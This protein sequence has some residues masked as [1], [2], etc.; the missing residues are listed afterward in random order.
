MSSR[1]ILQLLI[2]PSSKL[3]YGRAAQERSW[4]GR[5]MYFQTASRLLKEERS[6]PVR[7]GGGGLGM[8][9]TNSGATATAQGGKKSSKGLAKTNWSRPTQKNT[10]AT[11]TVDGKRVAPKRD[12]SKPVDLHSE[13][14]AGETH[15][16][17]ERH[18]NKFSKPPLKR[19]ETQAQKRER[20]KREEELAALAKEEEKERQQIA[21]R[22]AK[23]KAKEKEEQ[24]NQMKDV[25]IP[26][27]INVANLSKVLGIR[28]EQLIRTMDEL[29]MGNTSHD[30]MLNADE[31]SLI[32]MQLDMNP[33]VD[34]R[35]S[36]DLFPR[37]VT[38][39]EI[40]QTNRH[41]WHI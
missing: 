29:E 26:E 31:S 13:K 19:A 22:K 11:T 16:M 12:W 28:I 21:M 18:V 37:Q 10:T 17:H 1:K 15:K 5:P 34:S 40:A 8:P 9:S 39:T 23:Q 6:K 32:A 24:I 20:K 33:I 4:M 3:G 35:Q 25:Y 38:R 14:H 36:I 41:K 2:Q 30:R 27:I 7:G